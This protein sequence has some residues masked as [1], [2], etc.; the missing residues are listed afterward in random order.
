[1]AGEFRYAAVQRGDIFEIEFVGFCNLRNRYAGKAV[2]P[3]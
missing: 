2:I 1:M 3:L